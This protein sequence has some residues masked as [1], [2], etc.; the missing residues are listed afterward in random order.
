MHNLETKQ[1]LSTSGQA[2]P[3]HMYGLGD[4]LCSFHHVLLGFEG[5]LPYHYHA[6]GTT[7]PRRSISENLEHTYRNVQ[8]IFVHECHENPT[9]RRLVLLL[10]LLTN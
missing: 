6:T 3:P 4:A 9:C 8:N 2:P 5:S 7:H 10:Q 1:A